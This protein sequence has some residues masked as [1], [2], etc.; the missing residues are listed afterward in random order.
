[1]KFRLTISARTV[2]VAWIAVVIT[3]AA[4]LLIQRSVIRQQ[5][6]NMFRDGM[7]GVLLSAESTRGSV[8]KMNSMRDFDRAS[9]L[10]E[11]KKSSDFRATRFY[12]TIPVVAAW[13]TID[14]VAGKEGY[15][16][17]IPSNNPRNPKNAPDPK[18]Q[19]ILETFA[20]TKQ[21]EYFE[22]DEARNEVV[23][24]RP[25]LL[26]EDCMACHGNPAT[27]TTG[28]DVLGFPMEN[29][30]PGEMHGAFLLRGKL[31]PVDNQV[32]AGMGKAAMWL[33]PIAFLLGFGAFL[34]MK[35]IRGPL[36]EAMSVLQ[37]VS[38]G[39][40][41]R[42]L[43]VANNDEIGDMAVALQSMSE[44]LRATI[45]EIAGGVQ[46]L[47]GSSTKL[48]ANSAGMTTSSRNA[49]D[50]AHSVAAAAEEMSANVASVA[51][52]MEQAVSNLNS[53]ASATEE[54]TATIGEIASNSEKARRITNEAAGQATRITGQI[55]RLGD[56]AR[57]IGKVTDTINEISSQTNLLA[58]N[59]TIEA[60]RAGAAGKGFAVV[61][62]E[63]KQLAQQTAAATEDIKVRITG[64][65][66][67]TTDS[68]TEIERV[69]RV[70][71]EISDV[72]N[73]I[74][75]AIEEQSAV[76][77]DIASNINNATTSVGDASS[78][79][80]QSAQVSVEIANDITVVDQ[81]AGQIAG[82]SEEVQA[83]VV[84]LTKLGGT[85][86]E[87]MARFQV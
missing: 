66:S 39:D 33:I 58:L 53:V 28:K 84:E 83:T 1:M 38:Q 61:A 31:D 13:R 22:V 86:K 52:G 23:Y 49:S 59:A 32:K 29:W 3:A 69:S 79:V 30:R 17:R 8:S 25:I 73:S 71:H 68:I 50:K 44:S 42:E 34:V 57:E 64:V 5:G 63:I 11:A 87:M 24:A 16:F 21:A 62:N 15:Q 54:M 74:A 43:H 72:V 48:S 77:K 65:Q 76:T 12:D 70:I 14:Y 45:G 85:L 35:T 19:A 41:T 67:S 4:G 2:A 46:V 55:N 82:S 56:A 9:L 78:Q 75:A 18:E 80:A 27:S 6:L 7:R 60:A 20:K 26:S 51:A 47:T 40:L 10:A 37:S 81:A 36:S